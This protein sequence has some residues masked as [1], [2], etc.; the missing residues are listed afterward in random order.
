MKMILSVAAAAVALVAAP[1]AAQDSTSDFTGGRA[2]VNL[3][4][5]N[6]DV[7]GF[8]DFSYGAEIGY[9]FDAGGAV[10]GISG[11]IQDSADITREL[12]VTARA[13]ARVG[14][15]GLIYATGGYTNLRAYGFSLDGFKIGAGAEVAVGSQ[16]FVKAE[17][18]YYNYEL[19]VDGWQTRLGAGIRF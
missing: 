3:G 7:I 8:D 10:L 19:G 12:A 13:G 14:T 5:Y 11:E 18:L 6:D 15:K 4:F 17:Q 16:A 9:D 2:G 1:A